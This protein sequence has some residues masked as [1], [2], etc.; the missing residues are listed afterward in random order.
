MIDLLKKIG[1]FAL[2]IAGLIAL[3]SA[4]NSFLNN[5]TYLTMFFKIVRVIIDPL[6]FIIDTST[7]ITLVGWMFSCLMAYWIAR[8]VFLSIKILNGK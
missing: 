6:D 8:G 2:L 7:L 4:I 5:W 3:G 1:L